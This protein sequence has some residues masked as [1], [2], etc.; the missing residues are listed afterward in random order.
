MGFVNLETIDSKLFLLNLQRS[1]LQAR[2]ISSSAIALLFHQGFLSTFLLDVIAFQL[3]TIHKP[4]PLLFFYIGQMNELHKERE[5]N[6][7]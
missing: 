5:L 7:V 2:W 6:N 4:Q 3:F 1:L